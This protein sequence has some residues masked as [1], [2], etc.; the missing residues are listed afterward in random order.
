MKG[1]RAARP[2]AGGRFAARLVLA[3]CW[4]LALAAYNPPE[5][6][7]ALTLAG[8]D[9]IA[10]FKV[11]SR[12]IA[13]GLLALVL[14]RAADRGRRLLV[15]RSLLPWALFSS[16]A[17]A[18][19]L[20]SPLKTFTLGHSLELVILLLLAMAVA[21]HA[22]EEGFLSS[23]ALNLVLIVFVVVSA[24][25]ALFLLDPSGGIESQVQRPFNLGHPNDIAASSGL[26]LLIL[27]LV[28]LLWKWRWPAF[29]NLPVALVC[30][31]FLLI[32]QSRTALFAF[33]TC[34]LVVFI[35][36]RR[37][38]GM[39][40]GLVAAALIGVFTL[41]A[42]FGDRLIEE[43]RS[44]VLRGQERPDFLAA[45]GRVELWQEA[46]GNFWE[47]PF[48]GFGYYVL[49]PRGYTEFA[50]ADKPT[51]GAH[52]L[53]LHVLTGTGLI[54]L[55]LFLWFVVKLILPH[56]LFV[57]L[58]GEQRKPSALVAVI[59]LLFFTIG[60]FEVSFLSAMRPS[61]VIFFSTLGIGVAS[62]LELRAP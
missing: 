51:F 44:Y 39:L 29:L 52:N 14:F 48:Q 37:R 12:V 30:G 20:W 4:I 56:F 61:V 33:A 21:Y 54:G 34:L 2:A 40:L 27:M 17:V 41:S 23:L 35:L 28:N 6:S 7:G 42:G 24:S 58:A 50:G 15:F 26:C 57:G 49:T 60:L 22:R 16:W 31:V 62:R 18:S 11:A 53:L 8:L 5:R 47:A 19:T 38:P 43:T 45:S 1:Q 10:L 59:M 25:L 9:W 55:T 3:A 46:L 36:F 32:A 13:C